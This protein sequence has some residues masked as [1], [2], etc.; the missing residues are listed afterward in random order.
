MGQYNGISIVL[1]CLGLEAV[2]EVLSL[3]AGPPKI[4]EAVY[5]VCLCPNCTAV[6]QSIVTI[7]KCSTLNQRQHV[8]STVP[9]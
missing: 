4:F 3:I 9:L 6:L 5:M 7:R 2:F 8:C 1:G